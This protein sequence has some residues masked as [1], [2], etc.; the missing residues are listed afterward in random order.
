MRQLYTL[1]FFFICTFFLSC[2]FKEIAIYGQFLYPPKPSDE[3]IDEKIKE[4]KLTS[5][6]PK[7]ARKK[8]QSKS[9]LKEKFDGELVIPITSHI[10]AY[11]KDPEKGFIVLT[12]RDIH[13]P[14]SSKNEI[15][16]YLIYRSNSPIQSTK[17]LDKAVKK[18]II[19]PGIER[20]LDRY[21]STNG[22]YFYAIQTITY[23]IPTR[24]VHYSSVFV[25]W[26]NS[27]VEPISPSQPKNYYANVP[28]IINPKQYSVSGK[29]AARKKIV[30]KKK[31]NIDKP[32]S[33]HRRLNRVLKSY[34]ITN[35]YAVAIRKLKNFGLEK[36]KKIRAKALFYLALSYY[37]QNQYD[38]AYKYFSHPTVQDFYSRRSVF[39]RQRTLERL[40]R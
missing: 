8:K 14:A 27:T 11:V 16:R 29:N 24:E 22:R 40:D 18:D 28:K 20:F 9:L 26:K 23:H 13:P 3:I 36:N 21:T 37:N 30:K 38:Q 10:D 15:Y 7:K 1:I 6:Q 5:S 32:A 19:D 31:S 39:W 17:D 4:R 33:S 25:K 2:L 35:K 12:W 34:Y